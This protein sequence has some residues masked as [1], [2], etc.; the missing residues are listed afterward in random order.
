MKVPLHANTCLGFLVN[1]VI[2]ANPQTDLSYKEIF[3]AASHGRL[4][5]LL[6]ER[7]GHLTNW[8]WVTEAHAARLEQMEAALCDAAS[9]FQGRMGR[10]TGHL[11]GI[12]LVMDII[13]ETLQRQFHHSPTPPPPP[14]EEPEWWKQD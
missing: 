5:P 3:D 13:L 1:D 11:S 9:A 2:R 7:Y 8:T 14:E 10:Q 4:I 6:V 12:C